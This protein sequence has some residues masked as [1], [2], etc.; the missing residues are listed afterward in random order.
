MEGTQGAAHAAWRKRCIL[1][2]KRYN[3]SATRDDILAL[4]RTSAPRLRRDF[5]VRSLSVFG[6][7]ARDQA[8]TNSDVDVLVEFE[9]SPSFK[10]FMRLK[11]ALEELLGRSVDRVTP[12]ALKPRLKVEVEREAIRVA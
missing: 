9:G 3:G 11:F 12:A 4:I 10:R 6:S 8:G 1:Q 5:H 7:F 2:R